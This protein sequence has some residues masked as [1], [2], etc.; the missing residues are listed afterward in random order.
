MRSASDP[1]TRYA[2]Q[3]T[4]GTIRTGQLVR[5]ACARHLADLAHGAERGLRWDPAAAEAALVF[6]AALR[7]S[8]GEWAGQPLRLE[9]WQ[10]FVVG[11]LIGWKRA[12]GLRRFRTSYQ[13]IARKNG[14]STLA[15]AFGLYLAFGDGEPGA[16]VYAAATKRDQ[17]KI[18]WSE[19]VR[20]VKRT[21]A[22][23]RRVRPFAGNLYAAGTDSKFEPLGRDSDSMD[24]LNPAGCIVDELHA[25]P[26]REVWDVLE[27]ALGSR[28][29]PLMF[30][31]TT[32]GVDQ[33][34]HSICWSQ[35]DFAVKVLEGVVPD[36]SLFAYIAT[37][38]PGDKW[39]DPGNWV[40]ANP[41][42]GVSVKLDDLATLAARA[43]FMPAAVQAFRRL[44]LN[45]WV[46]VADRWLDPA[47]WDACAEPIPWADLKGQR[48]VAGL[49][50][51]T[52]EDTTALVLVFPQPDGR[53]L[54]R[55]Y[56][57]VPADRIRLRS[58]RDKVPYD[59][60]AQQGL[61]T[62]T[63]GDVVDY[64]AIEATIRAVCAEYRVEELAFDKWNATDLI[65]RLDHDG[66]TKT[67]EFRQG[68]QSLS[69]P[70]K[71]LSTLIRNGLLRHDGHPVL[72]WHVSN[73]Y[74]DSDA[75]ENL[76]PSKKRSTDRIDG[77]VAL[78]MGLARAI[79]LPPPKVSKYETADLAVMGA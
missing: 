31:I 32:A 70:F 20:M 27:T 25:H 7:H 55:P 1:A 35:R 14:K 62:A 53:V 36:D 71:L 23:L 57:W 43:E 4:Q 50:L 8:K 48:C 44:R 34:R 13:E 67:V 73:V 5:L 37:L 40:K 22:L 3:V 47:L 63:P 16:E 58:A 45:E 28:R 59:Q 69:P 75:M 9:P 61:L 49:D 78:C 51:S 17:A 24:G 29:Q 33:D 46:N 41:N 18:V 76:K 77:V 72:R 30:A 60:W 64:R 66:V 52:T 19:A 15:A 56:F 26:S 79:A 74:A 10:Q 42:L 54:V 38:D 68:F 65:T 11:S 2:E 12:D 39:N 21:P 6:M